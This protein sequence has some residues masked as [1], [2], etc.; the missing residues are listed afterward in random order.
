[1]TKKL[2]LLGKIV[3][4]LLTVLV[5]LVFLF[6]FLKIAVPHKNAK[7]NVVS[8]PT[9]TQSLSKTQRGIILS[10]FKHA[11]PL[12]FDLNVDSNTKIRRVYF[13]NS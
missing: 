5:I 3:F 10:D 2:T 8:T 12:L 6:V 13:I 7:I 11:Y 4:G 1:M 9:V